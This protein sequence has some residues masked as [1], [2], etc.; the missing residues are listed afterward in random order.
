MEWCAAFTSGNR[1]RHLSVGPADDEVGRETL[2]EPVLMVGMDL[3]PFAK[4]NN[5][6]VFCGNEQSPSV[7]V[8]SAPVSLWQVHGA[9]D[10]VALEV[11]DQTGRR[12]VL[13]FD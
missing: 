8:I 1:G 9:N 7:N 13:T 5:F 3:D 11:E 6:V 4:G 10:V 12:T 2:A